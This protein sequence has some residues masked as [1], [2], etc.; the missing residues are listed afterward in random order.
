METS[1]K[2]ITEKCGFLHKILP[3]N[4][5]LAYR[6]FDI[7]ASIGA[8]IFKQALEVCVRNKKLEEKASYLCLMSKQQEKLPMSRSMLN[9]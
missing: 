9:E 6:G 3:G 7:Q 8:L 2:L 4:L 1:D 5:V